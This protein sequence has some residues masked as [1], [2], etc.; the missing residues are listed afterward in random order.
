MA[1]ISS[2]GHP[3][4]PPRKNPGERDDFGMSPDDDV[5]AANG[6]YVS[7][8]TEEEE[9]EEEKAEEDEE[10][11]APAEVRNE[12]EGIHIAYPPSTRWLDL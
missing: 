10:A 1:N 12:T 3:K 11:G 5:R 9:E 7:V 8:D 2:H 4:T 6:T